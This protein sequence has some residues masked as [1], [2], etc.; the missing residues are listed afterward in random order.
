MLQ[1]ALQAHYRGYLLRRRLR[2]ILESAPYIVSVGEGEAG[3]EDG[4]EHQ[5]DLDEEVISL[6]YLDEVCVHVHVCCMC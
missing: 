3:G 1:F 4:G 5:L 6:D 2:D